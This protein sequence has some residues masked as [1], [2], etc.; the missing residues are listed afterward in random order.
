MV[1]LFSWQLQLFKFKVQ[2]FRSAASACENPM[3]GKNYF[4]LTNIF[5]QTAHHFAEG[6]RFIFKCIRDLFEI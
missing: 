6:F 3:S 1:A 2:I 4:N 5:F